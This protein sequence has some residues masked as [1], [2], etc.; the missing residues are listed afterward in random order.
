MQGKRSAS[1]IFLNCQV[2][3][4]FANTLYLLVLALI[5]ALGIALSVKTALGPDA[6]LDFWDDYYYVFFSH[7]IANYGFSGIP[8]GD[9]ATE[10]ILVGVPAMV[11]KAFGV[12]I[13]TEGVFSML[14]LAGTVITIFMIG[15]LLHN[16]LAGIFSALTFVFEPLVAAEGAASGDNMAVVFFITLAILLLLLGAK[17]KKTMYYFLSGFIGL[18]GVLAG[19]PLNLL[20]FL[21][22]IPYVIYLQLKERNTKQ[23]L[24]T[25]AFF[26]G[27]L[28]AIALIIVF[29]FVLQSNPFIYFATNYLPGYLSLSTP[30][31]LQYI[32]ILFP[33]RPFSGNWFFWPLIYNFTGEININVIGFFGYAMLASLAYLVAKKKYGSVSLLSAWFGLLFLYLSFGKDSFSAGYILFVERFTIILLPPIALAIGL[34]LSMIAEDAFKKGKHG[35]PKRR[36]ILHK[37]LF[38]FALTAYAIMV[39]NSLMLMKFISA[40]NYILTYQYQQVANVLR[41]LP[42]NASIY[43]ISGLSATPGQKT[44]GMNIYGTP[45]VTSYILDLNFLN[46]MTLED[47]SGYRINANYSA[48]FSN[49][50]A[51]MGD[52]FVVVN[53]TYYKN[54]FY[55]CKNFSIYYSPSPN[56]SVLKYLKAMEGGLDIQNQNQITIYKAIK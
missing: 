22:L 48:V 40:G 18:I 7:Y 37:S 38:V 25:F 33:F 44:E 6:F 1:K 46:W 24:H 30:P 11:Y 47:Y 21:F 26:A 39:I 56:R 13:L 52:Y 35:R 15:K 5:I 42:E 31:V 12:S 49:C 50:S 17:R 34:A 19:S 28:L 51:V 45:T 20:V 16:G 32:S 3:I 27:I 14:C 29:G 55:M 41:S 53:T 4:P 43:I 36:N 23:K 9:F 2:R 10:Y 8:L 54:N